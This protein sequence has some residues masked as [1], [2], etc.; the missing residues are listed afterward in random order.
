MEEEEEIMMSAEAEV[1]DLC[2]RT[3][4]CVKEIEKNLEEKKK[5]EADKSKESKKK[6]VDLRKATAKVI[7]EMEKEANSSNARLQRM[8][9]QKMPEQADK[10]AMKGVEKK[11]EGVVSKHGVKV[12]GDLW[13]KPDIDLKKKKFLLKATLKF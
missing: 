9:E 4:K 7:A 12:G 8:L 5:L 13:L 11:L 6:L 3:E 1:K 2:K 10:G